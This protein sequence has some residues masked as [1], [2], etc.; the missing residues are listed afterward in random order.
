M[1]AP[2]DRTIN[3]LGGRWLM[4]RPPPP[5]SHPPLPR[6]PPAKLKP[7]PAHPPTNPPIPHHPL[8]PPAEPEA[9]RQ[10]RARPLPPG[11]LLPPP[12]DHLLRLRHPRG[13]PVRGPPLS[14]LHRH[15]PRPAHR[16]P[17]DRHRRPQGHAGAALPRRGRPPPLGLDLRQRQGPLQVHRAR[18]DRGRVPQERVAAGRGGGDGARG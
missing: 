1:A 15:R 14:P 11:H 4:V 12:Q 17:A 2:A 9:L 8:T 10:R 16:H 6:H 7:S 18:G 3:S 5:L 13:H